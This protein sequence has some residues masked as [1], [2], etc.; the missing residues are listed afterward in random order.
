MPDGQNS[1]MRNWARHVSVDLGHPKNPLNP[2]N[3]RGYAGH[4]SKAQNWGA[5]VG[6]DLGRPSALPSVSKNKL[7]D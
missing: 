3:A 5:R 4:D 1:P 6:R 2:H 7:A